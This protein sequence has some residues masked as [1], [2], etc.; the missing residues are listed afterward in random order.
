MRRTARSSFSNRKKPPLPW[1]QNNH[2][3]AGSISTGLDTLCPP[4]H[5][6]PT[7][8]P[9]PSSLSLASCTATRTL[10][11]RGALLIGSDVYL[12]FGPSPQSAM[13]WNE[14]LIWAWYGGICLVGILLKHR[15]KPLNVLGA[16]LPSAISFFL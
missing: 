2:V 4:P 3:S 13:P 6:F 14:L 7:P 15:A 1:R 10:R 5:V 16:S 9:G 11:V 12:H 8:L